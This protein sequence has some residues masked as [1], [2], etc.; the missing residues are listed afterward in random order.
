MG[1]ASAVLL[2]VLGTAPWAFTRIA[3]AAQI[4]PAGTAVEHADAALILGARVYEDGTPSRFLRERVEIGVAL[5]TAGDVD[6]LIMSGDGDD[7]SGFGEPAVM[8]QVAEEM[9]VP[10]S[11]ITEDPLGLDTYSSCERARDVY[12]ASSVVVATQE[13]HEPRAVWLCEQEG[14]LTQGRYPSVR[15]TKST[16]IGNVREIPATAKAVLD[17]WTGRGAASG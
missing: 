1:I 3:T 15:L 9:G 14:L 17:Q 11:A 12:G 4:A 2:I 13:F 7:S 16:V 6:A 10:P 5:Y 8:R